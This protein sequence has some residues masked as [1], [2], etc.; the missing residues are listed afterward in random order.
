MKRIDTKFNVVWTLIIFFVYSLDYSIFKYIPHS[1][2]KDTIF[3]NIDNPLVALC[4]LFF[5]AILMVS[6]ISKLFMEI[7][8]RLIRD[9][10]SI[11]YISF[12]E[13]YAL[14]FLL[15]EIIRA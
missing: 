13:S 1:R 15:L 11:G 7:W 3:N 12:A 8:N 5:S 9:L 14:C 6:V 10:L 2:E 4:V